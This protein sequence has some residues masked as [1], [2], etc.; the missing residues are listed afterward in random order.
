MS[1]EYLPHYYV[2]CIYKY[3]LHILSNYL[4]PTAIDQ[5]L[6]SK[7]DTLCYDMYKLSSV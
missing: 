7:E 1:F 4:I 5:L 6:M 3:F 2:L